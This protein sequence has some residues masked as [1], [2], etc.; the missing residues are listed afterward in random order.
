MRKCWPKVFDVPKEM[1]QQVDG[2]LANADNPKTT[3]RTHD[4]E[5]IRTDDGD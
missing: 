2:G 1:L 5:I 3:E 4:A